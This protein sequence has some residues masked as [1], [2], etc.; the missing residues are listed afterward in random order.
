[1]KKLFYIIVLLIV[2]GCQEERK[3]I[4]D[5]EGTWYGDV[6]EGLARYDKKIVSIT[7][8]GGVMKLH[9][10]FFSYTSGWYESEGTYAPR[11]DGGADFYI[12]MTPS[13]LFIDH[14]DIPIITV[15]HAESAYSDLSGELLKVFYTKQYREDYFDEERRGMSEQHWT[16]FSRERPTYEN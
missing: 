14:P 2:C 15:T 10:A 12:T 8:E 9:R 11:T 5:I 16:W 13:E 1:M 6:Q 4:F 3:D 7:L